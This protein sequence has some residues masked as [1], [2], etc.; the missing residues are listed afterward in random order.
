VQLGLVV[1]RWRELSRSAFS[2]RT[3]TGR[4]RA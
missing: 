4:W 1:L 2:R 3:N